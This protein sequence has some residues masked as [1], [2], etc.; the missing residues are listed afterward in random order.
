VPDRL[1]GV[2]A[3]IK[4]SVRRRLDSDSVRAFIPLYYAPILV[5]ALLAIAWPTASLAVKPVMGETLTQI[6]VWVQVPFTILPMAGLAL[7]HGGTPTLEMTTPLLARD[8]WGLGMQLAGHAVMF[9]VLLAFVVAA[10][11]GPYWWILIYCGFLISSYV[12]GCALLS[13][14]VLRK[15]W[16]G[17]Q[18]KQGHL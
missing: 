3:W 18:L 11:A 16:R 6:W 7:R 14:Q 8:W 13:T 4:A 17:Q 1:R 9:W 12:G 10:M 2:W 15:V 5:Y